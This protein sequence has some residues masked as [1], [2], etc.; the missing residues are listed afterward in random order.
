MEHRQRLG[1]GDRDRPEL[2]LRVSADHPLRRAQGV[3]LLP[4]SGHHRSAPADGG[5]TWGADSY[6]CACK[7]VK[8]QNDPQIAVA[9]D[10]TLY[11]AWLNDY[12]PGVVF[13]KSTNHGATW[14][15]PKS[16]EGKSPQLQRQADPR[17]LPDREGR[18]H[19]LQLE[20][21]LRGRLA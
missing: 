6:I 18:L 13:S 16:V 14:S 3:R 21:Q 5:A 15:T 11:A 9:S 20:R 8:A 1:A 12:Q 2:L 4:G 19:R 7:N 17:D 10:G